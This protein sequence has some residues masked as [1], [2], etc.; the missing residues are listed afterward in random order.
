ML[1][2]AAHCLPTICSVT[3]AYRIVAVVVVSNKVTAH[4]R[5]IHLAEYLLRQEL[6]VV[7]VWRNLSMIEITAAIVAIVLA[8][9][10]I[11][12]IS[13]I[14]HISLMLAKQGHNVLIEVDL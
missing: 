6:R 7:H 1:A 14:G 8:I 10:K 4:L 12:T 3:V 11:V 5:L 2:Y 13:W 9:S